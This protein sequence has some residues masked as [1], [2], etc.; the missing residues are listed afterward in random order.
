MNR[1]KSIKYLFLNIFSNNLNVKLYF[2]F[3]KGE[4]RLKNDNCNKQFEKYIKY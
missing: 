2:T 3:E 1:L 4:M